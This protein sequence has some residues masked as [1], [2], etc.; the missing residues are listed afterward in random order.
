MHVSKSLKYKAVVLIALCYAERCGFKMETLY[1]KLQKENNN[2]HIVIS[3]LDEIY[4]DKLEK[5]LE[6]QH[7]MLQRE[8]MEESSRHYATKNKLEKEEMARIDVEL[9]FTKEKKVYEQSKKG[10][11]EEIARLRQELESYN[12]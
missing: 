10:M 3:K 8:I 9:A 11:S 7:T 2:Q 6:D 12:F 1:K 4:R 5:A